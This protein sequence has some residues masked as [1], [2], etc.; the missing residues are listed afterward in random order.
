VRSVAERPLFVLTP[1]PVLVSDPAMDE[2]SFPA[3]WRF[4]E[5]PEGYRVLDATIPWAA[6]NRLR[7]AAVVARVAKL[8]GSAGKKRAA[9][10]KNY[11]IASSGDGQQ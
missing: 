7:V 10:A 4:E 9:R 1:V 3:P 5:I 11:S 6:A 2:R 8:K